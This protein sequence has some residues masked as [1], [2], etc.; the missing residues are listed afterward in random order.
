MVYSPD[1][2]SDGKLKS[3]FSY[4]N[5]ARGVEPKLRFKVE[6]TPGVTSPDLS[7]DTLIH[8]ILLGPMSSSPLALNSVRHL[9]DLIGKGHLRD[10]VIGSSIPLRL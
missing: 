10:R 6:A 2:D 9:L 3:M 7:L 1:R 5:G 4:V 8:S